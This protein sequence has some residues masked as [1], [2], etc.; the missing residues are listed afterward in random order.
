M[1]V[2][3][4]TTSRPLIHQ[5]IEVVKHRAKALLELYKVGTADFPHVAEYRQ[6]V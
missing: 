5:V 1:A 3:I 4:A 6:L 2:T